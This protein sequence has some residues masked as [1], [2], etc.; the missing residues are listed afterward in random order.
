MQEAATSPSVLLLA[1]RFDFTCDFVA[2]ALRRRGVE[3]LRLNSEDLPNCSLTLDPVARRLTGSLNDVQFCIT[4]TSLRSVLFRRPVFLRDYGDD[5]SSAQDRFIRIQWASFMQNLALFDGARWYNSPS[6]TYR[7]EHK[8]IQ[9]HEAARI[10]MRV[11]ATVVTNVPSY[12]C[13]SLS[14]PQYAIKGLDTVMVRE[15]GDEMFGF[16]TF[17]DH[18]CR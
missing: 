1:S 15:D 12:A 16:T 11:P 13:T 4:S 3:Y 14:G 5:H 6:S 7:A 2:A 10:G 18:P 8:A 17:A 9:L